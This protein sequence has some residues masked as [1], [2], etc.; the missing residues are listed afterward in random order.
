MIIY[1]LRRLFIVTLLTATLSAMASL[2]ATAIVCHFYGAQNAVAWFMTIFIVLLVIT[3]T[4]WIRRERQD[5]KTSTEIARRLNVPI[6]DVIWLADHLN[7]FAIMETWT[8]AEFLSNLKEAR[9]H[10]PNHPSCEEG[11]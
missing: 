5:F 2:T 7:Q 10:R 1:E 6:G 11:L 8:R 9:N 3:L 4:W